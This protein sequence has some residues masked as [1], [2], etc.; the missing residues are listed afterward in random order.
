MRAESVSL[1]FYGWLSIFAA[2]ITI[3]LKSYAFWL[4]NSVGLL[5]DALESVI[6]LLA[7]VI[8]LMALSIAARPPDRRHAYGHD[9][10][11]YFSSGAEGLMIMLAAAGIIW[12]A[13]ARLQHSQPLRDLDLGVAVAVFS[14]LINLGL[15][16][17]LIRVGKQRRS[18]PLEA[19][20]RHLMADVWTTVG[21]LTGIALI[22]IGDH[23]EETR[24]LAARLGLPDWRIVDPIIAFLVAGN[25][26]ASGLHLLGRTISGLLDAALPD[27]EQAA[28]IGILEQAKSRHAID[29]HALR[30]RCA[31]ARRFVS[32]HILVPGEWTVKQGHDLLERIEG[33]MM[34]EFDNIDIDTHL[35]PIEDLASWRH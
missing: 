7:A 13:W 6:N 3:A 2:I 1:T 30:T 12:T 27:I 8:M 25:V 17:V 29:Y 28:I 14:S 11:E 26:F 34:E 22:A 23:F 15:A 4:T 16:R 9:K 10:V 5:S 19:D 24:Q 18:L 32:V 20:G 21:V 35:E 31:G 33:E